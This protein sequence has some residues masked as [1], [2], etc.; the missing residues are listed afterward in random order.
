MSPLTA[1]LE[2]V[3][4]TSLK[5]GKGDGTAM[6]YVRLMTTVSMISGQAVPGASQ[7]MRTGSGIID[8]LNG[9]TEDLRRLVW[10]EAALE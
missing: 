6:D 4:N 3:Q 2:T 5:I 9:D 10:S 8:L 1:L 7:I